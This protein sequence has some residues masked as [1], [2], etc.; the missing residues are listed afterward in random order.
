VAERR[1]Q[2]LALGPPIWRLRLL[3]SH[4]EGCTL[5]CGGRCNAFAAD[6]DNEVVLSLASDSAPAGARIGDAVILS[7]DDALLR[8]GAWA[9]YGRVW[10]GLLVGSALGFAAGHL[11]A[12]ESDLPTLAGLLLG[13]SLAIW[14][15]KHHVARPRL[16]I[17][18]D[19]DNESP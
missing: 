11:L 4:C 10:L 15:S 3:D 2:L 14:R 8:R 16:A 7:I 19:N 18:T 1:A 17:S 6:H 5:G 13:T 9:G 12:I